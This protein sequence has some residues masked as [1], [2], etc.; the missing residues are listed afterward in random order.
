[1]RG[2]VRQH[3]RRPSGRGLEHDVRASL[4]RADR[5]EHRRGFHPRPDVGDK[6]FENDPLGEISLRDPASDIRSEVAFADSFSFK[7][8]ARPGTPV[9]RRDLP[10]VPA[11]EAQARLEELQTLQRQLTLRAHRAR[12]GETCRVLVDGPSRRGGAQ[13]TGRCPQ[14]RV[15]NFSAP[16]PPAPG[17]LAQL[18]IVAA[19]PH[20]LLAEVP[21]VETSGFLPL[22]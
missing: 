9:L 14:N 20:S 11:D 5:D 12:V 19:T 13:L 4:V 21:A 17:A 8:S 6:T 22:V 7:Y 15:V 2:D 18:R 10:E 16:V 1:M 3:Q